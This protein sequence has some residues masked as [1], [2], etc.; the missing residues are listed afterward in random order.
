MLEKEDR[1]DWEVTSRKIELWILILT[2]KGHRIFKTEDKMG[3]KLKKIEVLIPILLR[4]NREGIIDWEA[5]SKK[6]ELQTLTLMIK[7]LTILG[8]EEKTDWKVMPKEIELP[9]H[10]STMKEMIKID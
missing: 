4:L 1:T 9:N 6:V 2:M 8:K 5:I 7:V 10:T 3:V